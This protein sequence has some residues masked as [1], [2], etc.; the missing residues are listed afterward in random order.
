MFKEIFYTQILPDLKSRG[1]TVIAIT[2]DDKYFELADR[3][4][5]LDSGNVVFDKRLSGMAAQPMLASKQEH[6]AP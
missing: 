3:L 5:K 1:K 2:H 6:A 4:V